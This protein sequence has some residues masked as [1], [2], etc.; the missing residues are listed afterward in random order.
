MKVAAGSGM[1]EASPATG[2]V[3]VE[4]PEG[5]DALVSGLSAELEGEEPPE[6]A[7]AAEEPEGGEAAEPEA[8][9]EAEGEEPDA[10]AKADEEDAERPEI[11]PEVQAKIDA[12]IGKEVGRRK[13]AEEDLEAERRSHAETRARLDE[14]STQAREAKLAQLGEADRLAA[15]SEA[16]LDAAETKAREAVSHWDQFSE[17]GVT[18]EDGREISAADVRR[19]VRD[20]QRLLDVTI[21]RARAVVADRARVEATLRKAAPE[22]FDPKTPAGQL[23]E[24]AVTQV[25]GLAA[26]RIGRLLVADAAA[27]MALRQQQAALQKQDAPAPQPKAE[28]PKVPG[29]PAQSATR[30]KTTTERTGPEVPDLTKAKDEDSLAA[31]LAY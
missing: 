16:E 31:A 3:A 9:A 19:F 2:D 12:R 29:R 20:R 15:M 24:Q 26:S 27:G 22:V 10:E 25:P 30:R 8:D 6:A 5:F 11:P 1:A 17:D 13:E 18:L 7:P 21:P 23:W 4:S 28:P 14:L